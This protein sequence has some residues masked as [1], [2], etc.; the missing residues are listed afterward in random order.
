MLQ[1]KVKLIIIQTIEWVYNL[2]VKDV[3]YK[4]IVCLLTIYVQT[5]IKFKINWTHFNKSKQFY[6]FLS[7]L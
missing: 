4:Q 3:L 6:I 5:V 7:K 1:N 2:S